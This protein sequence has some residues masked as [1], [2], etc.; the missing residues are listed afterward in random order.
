MPRYPIDLTDAWAKVDRAKTHINDLRSRIT[1]K[2]GQE[3]FLLPLRKE[4]ETEDGG[5]DRGDFVFRIERLVEAEKGWGPIAGDAIHNLRSALDSLA[6]QLALR[7]HNGVI[8]PEQVRLIHFPVVSDKTK[9]EV[10]GHRKNMFKGDAAKLRKFQPFARRR[11]KKQRIGA[12]HPIPFVTQLPMT[13]QIHPLGEIS[14]FDND[15]KHKVVNPVAAFQEAVKMENVGNMMFTNCQPAPDAPGTLIAYGPGNPPQPGHIV[16][17]IPV[18][19]TGLNPDV[20]F[21]ASL[22]GY[23]ALRKWPLIATLDYFVKFVERILDTF[24]SG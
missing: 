5:A 3:P 9:W 20:N 18:V 1:Q 17:R 14:A 6:W 8:P 4:F 12:A 10:S 23:I 15:D 16:F 22:A 19:I 21:K 7:Y 24:Q 2:I 11:P 13:K